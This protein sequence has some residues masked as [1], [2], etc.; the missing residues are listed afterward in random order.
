MKRQLAQ[1]RTLRFERLETRSLLAAQSWNLAADF[2]ADFVAGLPQDNPNGVWTYLGTDGTTSSLVATNG[3]SPN[4]FGVGAGWADVSGFPSYARGGV[5]GFPAQSMAGHGPNRIVWTAPAAADMGG[6]ELTGLF[7]QATFEPTRQMQLRISKNDS[8]APFLIVDANF[9]VQNT[10]VPLPPT[11]VTIEPGDTLTIDIDGGGPFGDGVSSTFAAWNVAIQEIQLAGDYSRDGIVD[12]ADYTV[13]RNRLGAVGTPGMVE[14]DGTTT[15]NLSGVPDGIVN[16]SD[17]QFWKQEFGN[18]L[19]SGI[20][21]FEYHPTA[22]IVQTSGVTLPDG[23]LL[24]IT[25]TQTQGL[26]EAFGYSAQKGWDVFVLPGT[27]TL[28]A[29]LD[30]AALKLRTFRFE[31]VTLNF[32]SGV[33][34]FGIR[35][36]SAMQVDWYWKGGALNAPYATHGVLYQPHSLVPKDGLINGIR[37]VIDSRFEFNA[38]I[39][40]AT[41]KVTMD[42]LLAFVNDAVFAFKNVPRSEIDFAGTSFTETNIFSAPRSDD[43]IPFDLFSPA[44]R[45]TVLAPKGQFGIPGPN[46]FATV[47]K[48]D[49]RPLD[50]SGSTTSGLQ[51]AFDYAASNSLD[52][53]VFARG[54]PNENQNTSYGHYTLNTPL[55][56]G[57]LIDRIYRI[58]SVT[59]LYPQTGG[60]VLALNDV[61]ASDFELTGEV[62]GYDSDNVVR[63]KPETLGIANS[64]IRIGSPVATPNVDVNV[65]IDPSA[66]TISNSEFYFNEVNQGQ[67]GVRIDNPSPMSYFENNFLRAT[68]VHETNVVAVQLG[69]NQTNASNIRSNTMELRPAAATYPS[70]IALQVWGDY[71]FI[72]LVAVGSNQTYGAKFEPGSNNNTL[73]YGTIIAATPI[74]N[75]GTNN[76]FFHYG[77]GSGTGSSSANLAA[78]DTLFAATGSDDSATTGQNVAL[79]GAEQATAPADGEEALLL[80]TAAQPL[81]DRRQADAAATDAAFDDDEVAVNELPSLDPFWLDD[82]VKEWFPA[83]DQFA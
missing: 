67:F 68:H 60:I 44:G 62:V 42:T 82:L 48:P 46:S 72:D 34:D 14:G 8:Y 31:D 17:Y 64:V 1:R 49:G 51:E 24:D 36:D 15:G 43:P 18:S 73:F 39:I 2:A 16:E 32:T 65:L 25:G 63:I 45:V 61:V 29:H 70:L 26:Q 13:W 7:T 27:Y 10:I 78:L 53:V 37:G 33:T 66:R 11:R 69:Q 59:F 81:W 4:T 56:V 79:R 52:V 74:A 58:Y 54:V 23:T 6:I 22:I 21:P 76:T 77:S 20:R 19:D 55:T 41:Q 30:L 3:A 57:S 12:A 71:N 83:S 40:A 47:V 28:N 9:Q 50:V 5:F 35:F 80:V 38:D 75:F